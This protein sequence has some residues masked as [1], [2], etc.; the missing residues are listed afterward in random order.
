[1][2]DLES[3]L[4]QPCGLLPIPY[5]KNKGH[6]LPDDM[7]IV[8]HR[9][10]NAAYLEE[11]SDEEYFRLFHSLQMIESVIPE[12]LY[13]KTVEKDDMITVV[14]I[15]NH[16]YDD[17]SVD[18]SQMMGYTQTRVYD[19]DLWVIVYDKH[20]GTPIGCGIA[21]YDSEADEGILEWIQVIPAYRKREVG[22]AIV[23]LLLYRLRTKANFVTV[24]GKVKNETQPEALY[25]KCGFVGNDI[26]HILKKTKL[27]KL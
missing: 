11:Y 13:F 10:F 3:Y 20:D 9:D 16:S 25:R 26:W 8:H 15:I 2:I 19:K 7:L 12:W 18:I 24:S 5:W 14:S 23:H 27:R 6:V 22:T 17:L 1:M 21:D 4:R